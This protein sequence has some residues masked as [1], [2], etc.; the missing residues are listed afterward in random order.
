MWECAFLPRWLQHPADPEATYEGGDE[1]TRQALRA[2]FM[3][4]VGNGQ[5]AVLYELGKPF[6]QLCDRLHFRV[7]VWLSL[8]SWVDERLAWA[9]DH[10]G[11]GYPES[12]VP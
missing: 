6:R 1:E 10:P 8:E 3:D 11:I 2:I 12:E 4:K 5:W 9:K 7:G